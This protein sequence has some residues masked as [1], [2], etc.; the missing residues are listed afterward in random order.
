MKGVWT[1]GG[2]SVALGS[3]IGSAVFLKAGGCGKDGTSSVNGNAE[4]SKG[5]I[6]YTKIESQDYFDFPKNYSGMNITFEAI[7]T[8]VEV[9]SKNLIL[10][11]RNDKEDERSPRYIISSGKISEDSESYKKLLRLKDEVDKKKGKYWENIRVNGC[12]INNN[13]A[14]LVIESIEMDG[15]TI[16]LINP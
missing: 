9:S 3:I 4:S 15:E 16:S 14:N 6:D 13:I 11:V 1:V 5:G 2:V 12:V 8:Y 10:W 7:P